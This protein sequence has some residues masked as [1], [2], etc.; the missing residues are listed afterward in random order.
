[1]EVGLNAFIPLA[2]EVVSF[3]SQLIYPWGK[4]P[5]YPLDRRLGAPQ[6]WSGHISFEEKESAII[7][8]T[9]N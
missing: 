5:W 4:T 9:G 6:S 7:V 2:L 1:V 8:P 3:T